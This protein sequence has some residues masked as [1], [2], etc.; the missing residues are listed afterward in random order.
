MIAFGTLKGKCKKI[1]KKFYRAEF[2]KI[3]KKAILEFPCFFSDDSFQH[4]YIGT[5]K[6]RGHRTFSYA[7]AFV[8]LAIPMRVLMHLKIWIL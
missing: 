8:S 4:Y 6:R 1:L 3:Y 5:L 2:Q 7:K